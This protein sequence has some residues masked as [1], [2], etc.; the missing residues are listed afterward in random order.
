MRCST[1]DTA[2][3]SQRAALL[4]LLLC[5]V[6]SRTWTFGV[7]NWGCVPRADSLV[8]GRAVAEVAKESVA[9]VK[10]PPPSKTH[11]QLALDELGAYAGYARPW[12]TSTSHV[13]I[14]LCP[15]HPRFCPFHQLTPPPP[16][17]PACAA[18][19]KGPGRK[20][21]CVQIAPAPRVAMGEAFG[22][23]PGAISCNQIVT[24]L[25]QLGFDYVFGEEAAH[26][27]QFEFVSMIYVG[28]KGYTCMHVVHINM[29]HM[30]VICA[31]VCHPHVHM[32]VSHLRWSTMCTCARSVNMH[33]MM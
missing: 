6:L 33:V 3:G 22:L 4:C 13:D 29:L 10:A 14:S 20:L 32:H 26:C 16:P 5:R 30:L 2:S 8:V 17:A 15:F 9:E 18:K 7:V 31:Y 23:A 1:T 11:L 24:A 21:C 12:A 19:P 28:T 27:A 25:K